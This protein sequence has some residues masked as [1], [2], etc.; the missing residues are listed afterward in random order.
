MES[1]LET[2]IML[3][4][5]VRENDPGAFYAALKLNTEDRQKFE[6]K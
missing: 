4:N 3:R 1:H 5:I 2:L 6:V